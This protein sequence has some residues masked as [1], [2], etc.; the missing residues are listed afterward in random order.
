MNR[1][2]KFDA[3]LQPLRLN[4]GHLGAIVSAVASTDKSDAPRIEV[5]AGCKV[6]DDSNVQ[7]RRVGLIENGAFTGSGH[8]NLKPCYTNGEALVQGAILLILVHTAGSNDDRGAR[9]SLR[10][11]QIADDLLALKWDL[12]SL[13]R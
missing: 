12:H 3:G 6:I 11:A 13:K 9:H 8:V 7:V 5:L 2:A 1:S 4:V 10:L